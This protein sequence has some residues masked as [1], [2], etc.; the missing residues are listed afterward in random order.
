MKRIISTLF[1]LAMLVIPAFAQV[2]TY[3]TNLN[4]AQPPPGYNNWAYYMNN[5]MGLLDAAF[6]AG[7]IPYQGTWLSTITYGK[8]VFVSYLGNLYASLTVGN[9]N[10]NPVSS[11]QWVLLSTSTPYPA[12]GL[13]A[14]TGSG[15]R[16]PVFGDVTTLFGG[17]TCTGS[18]QSDG[19]CLNSIVKSINGASNAFTFTGSGFAGCTTLGGTTT[20]I[21]TGGS[22]TG[23]PF[24]AASSYAF[25]GDSLLMVSTTNNASGLRL[26]STVTA[27]ACDGTNCTVTDATGVGAGF[28]TVGMWLLPGADTLLGF[29]PSCMAVSRVKV[30]SIVGNN[31]GFSEAQTI[32]PAGTGGTHSTGCTGV[33]SGTGGTIQDA[34]N[35]SPQQMSYMTYFNHGGV[36]PPPL[37]NW[38][39]PGQTIAD[40]AAHLTATGYMTGLPSGSFV[41]V[42]SNDFCGTN[43][44][45]TFEGYLQTI[46][47]SIHAAGHKA[48]LSTAPIGPSYNCGLGVTG[49][50]TYAAVTEWI[51][52]NAQCPTANAPTNCYDGII[53]Q[54]VYGVTSR[55]DSN[56]VNQT[57]TLT[58]HQTDLGNRKT[59][60]VFQK[61]LTDKFSNN[62]GGMIT[63]GGGTLRGMVNA[64]AYAIGQPAGFSVDAW[65]IYDI[66]GFTIW[67]ALATMYA[68]NRLIFQPLASFCWNYDSTAPLNNQC[69]ES[70]FSRSQY[71]NG[72]AVSGFSDA[73]HGNGGIDTSNIRPTGFTSTP[74]FVV[75]GQ[76]Y[77]RSDLHQWCYNNNGTAQCG[78]GTATLTATT[79]SAPAYVADSGTT[80]TF[81]AT[82]SPAITSY[83][84]GLTVTIKPLAS[85]VG[86]TPTLNVNTLGAITIVK[87]GGSLAAGDIMAGFL[88][89][90]K[91][92]GTH[93]ELQ[94]PQTAVAT[95]VN[96]VV[97]SS[98]TI[99]ASCGQTIRADNAGAITVTLPAIIATGCGIGVMRGV[100]AG[101]V[102]INPNGNTY[103]GVTTSL[104]QG[105]A[106]FV[107]TDGTA[108]HSSGSTTYSGCTYTPSLTGNSVTCSGS[109]IANTT[110]TTNTTAI[111]ANT[112]V[113]GPGSPVAMTGVATTSVFDVVPN[114]DITGV[115]GW[116]NF[117]GLIISAWPTA[118]AFNFKVC[119]QTGS[120]ITPGASVTW[121][122]GAR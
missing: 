65:S 66:N 72:V 55:A 111:A 20:C 27:G 42:Q 116:G 71:G 109:G 62:T 89:T 85:N 33:V 94:N 48:F 99:S 67:S 103:D 3:T 76:E 43:N 120:S 46:A 118:N 12:A 121:N 36:S 84:A 75:D 90:F 38:S 39:W 40:L 10:N 82:L 63:A 13:A 64:S 114:A 56:L 95:G 73:G 91:Y 83:T 86:A 47:T 88:A 97:S 70:G 112:C 74:T 23:I 110:V 106:V 41:F 15:W 108:Y 68:G 24:D 2:I 60:E 11:G 101:V 31:V 122:V 16:A 69:D 49:D 22:G 58:G 107:W 59:A 1:I 5:N 53:D 28:Y 6:G 104:P 25:F 21:F 52:Q 113:A 44:A 26:S 54:A 61:A 29:S 19:T 9:L 37:Y 57:G 7:Q 105:Q 30:T 93:F 51:Q 81:V 18:L 78:W 50:A 32:I 45:A 96:G 80:D 35:L 115:N 92:D 117:G 98:T 119:N 14:S 79:I 17:G 34:S 87:G 77:Y 100:S 4:L 102:T 8:G